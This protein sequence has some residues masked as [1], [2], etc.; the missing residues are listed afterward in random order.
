MPWSIFVLAGF[1]VTCGCGEHKTVTI[2]ANYLHF[3]NFLK[4][5]F[6]PF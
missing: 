3:G 2:V 6:W 1:L 5:D 4:N